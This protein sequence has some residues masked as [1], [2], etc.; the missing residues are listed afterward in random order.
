MEAPSTRSF[1][2]T[3]MNDLVAEVVPVGACL[4]DVTS[5]A[6]CSRPPI[7]QPGV[8]GQ[9]SGDTRT[10]C[11]TAVESSGWWP[12]GPAS[13]RHPRRPDDPAG[14]GSAK[15]RPYEVMA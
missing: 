14:H 2:R 1:V 12:A 6:G 9:P 8:H 5:P 3:E 15:P 10:S 4:G 7:W 11:M 13:C